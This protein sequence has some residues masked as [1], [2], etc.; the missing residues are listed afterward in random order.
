MA[1][2]G[3]G[4]YMLFAPSHPHLPGTPGN[5][6]SRMATLADCLLAMSDELPSIRLKEQAQGAR[7]AAGLAFGTVFTHYV[8]GRFLAGV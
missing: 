6:R 3:V 4:R 1:R 5:S 7:V 8:S 2:W